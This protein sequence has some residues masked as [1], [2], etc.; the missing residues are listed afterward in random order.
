V[1]PIKIDGAAGGD[2]TDFEPLESGRYPAKIASVEER[3]P[4]PSGHNYLVVKFTMQEGG[5]EG[6]A[7]RHAW[8]N[9]SFAP[10]SLWSLKQLL[11]RTKVSTAE[12]VAKKF[13]LDERE[14]VGKDVVVSLGPPS[15]TT[16]TFNTVLEVFEGGTSLD[17][18]AT[19]GGSSGRGW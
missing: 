11:I 4:G 7:G 1:S 15:D 10:Q 9:Y 17:D 12:Q 14:L 6:S 8:S 2:G 5:P 13:T 19:A 18:A 16:T 3:G